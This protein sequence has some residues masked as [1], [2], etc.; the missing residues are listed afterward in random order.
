MV[1]APDSPAFSRRLLCV[2]VACVAFAGCDA[3]PLGADHIG[4]R[5]SVETVTASEVSG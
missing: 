2:L 5:S 4:G 3:G 1:M